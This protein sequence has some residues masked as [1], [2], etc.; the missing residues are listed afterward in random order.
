MA[1]NPP[2]HFWPETCHGRWMDPGCEEGL[3][4]VII[5]T[6]NRAHFI[7]DA[8]DSGGSQVYH[9]IDYTDEGNHGRTH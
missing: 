3:V 2:E 1:S 8:M 5:P 6:Y 4:S 9:R 7:T